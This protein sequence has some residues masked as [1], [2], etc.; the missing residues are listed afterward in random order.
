MDPQNQDQ[1]RDRN[2]IKHQNG[3]VDDVDAAGAGGASGGPQRPSV[4]GA[5][6]KDLGI[7]G[8]FIKDLS[9]DL[10]KGYIKGYVKDKVGLSRGESNKSKVGR[11]VETLKG[12][13]WV[14]AAVYIS[15]M[16]SVL[17]IRFLAKMMEI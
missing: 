6:A 1:N 13:W 9:K 12:L 15:L 14:P 8:E 17:L 16:L 5:L 11:T 10:I 4:I 7:E 2:L 3:S